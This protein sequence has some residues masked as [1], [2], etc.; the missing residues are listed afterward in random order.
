[1]HQWLHPR[2]PA[3]R[4]KSFRSRGLRMQSDPELKLSE[5]LS[6]V[7]SLTCI[8]CDI[9]SLSDNSSARFLVPSTF[10]KVVCA[11]RRVDVC[12]FDTLATD[13]MGQCMRKYTT[14]STAT[15]T[16]SLVRICRVKKVTPPL[17]SVYTFITRGWFQNRGVGKKQ[18]KKS[19]TC[20]LW[21][22]VKRNSSQV[23]LHKGVS[24]RQDKEKPWNVKN[25][26]FCLLTTGIYKT[27]NKLVRS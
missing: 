25:K 6:R 12:A 15:V 20:L 2:T 8:L 14:P 13:E 26:S 3:R 4:I 5:N 17:H 27:D 18:K 22:D 9:P 23:N 7:F 24:A 1:M 10:L 11:S 21:R 16:E 19:E